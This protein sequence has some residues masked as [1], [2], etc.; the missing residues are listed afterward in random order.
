MWPEQEIDDAIGPERARVF[1]AH[2]FVKPGGNAVLSPRSDP[3][4]EFG[5]LNTLIER[6]SVQDTAKQFGEGNALHLQIPEIGVVT[7]LHGRSTSCT[8]A[9]LRQVLGAHHTQISGMLGLSVS[10]PNS[11]V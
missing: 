7:D 5:G 10:C 9:H 8:S 2:Y 3:H 6:Q 4:R 1:K 11:M